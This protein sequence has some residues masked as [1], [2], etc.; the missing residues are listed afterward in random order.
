[1]DAL[2]PAE[3]DDAPAAPPSAFGMPA[4]PLGCGLL[5]GAL[6]APP[7]RRWCFST[8]LRTSAGIP[9]VGHVPGRRKGPGWASL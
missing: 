1:M 7:S 4:H 9:A 8:S 2:D 3:A 6:F 5:G